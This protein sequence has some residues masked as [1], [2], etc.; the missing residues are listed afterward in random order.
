MRYCDF[1]SLVSTSGGLGKQLMRVNST[2]DVDVTGSGHQP[3]YRDTYASIYDNYAVVKATVKVTFTSNATT[4]S[5]ICGLVIEDDTSSSSNI[6]VLMEQS[7]GSH[8]M[9]PNNAGSLSNRSLT[10]TWDCA[11]YLNIDPFTSYA[12]KAP[13]GSDPND[14]AFCLIYVAPVDGSSTTTTFACVEVEQWVL[15]TEL[16]TPT[17]S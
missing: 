14:Q 13:V 12:Y 9:L 11:K 15:W 7:A 16:S 2:Y 5:M 8:L 10:Q 3:L 17:V 4:S 6:S 1:Y